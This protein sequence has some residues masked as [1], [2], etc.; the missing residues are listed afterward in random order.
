MRGRRL[1][2]L[3]HALHRRLLTCALLLALLPAAATAQQGE[4]GG[5]R[6]GPARG[7]L[8]IAGGGSLGSDIIGRFV[9]LAGGAQAR[10]VVLPAAGTEDEFPENW[11]GLAL[12]RRAGG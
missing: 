8:V 7:A 2:P 1:Q 4:D 10:I 12:F 3:T 9:D 11:S 6:V 5:P